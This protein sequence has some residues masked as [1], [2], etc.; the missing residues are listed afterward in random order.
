[1]IYIFCLFCRYYDFDLDKILYF[2]TVGRYE[3]FNK[4]ADMF[5]ELLVRLNF[6]FKVSILNFICFVENGVIR[7]LYIYIR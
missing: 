3:F 1:M 6:Y 7:R 4:G 5:I 2:F